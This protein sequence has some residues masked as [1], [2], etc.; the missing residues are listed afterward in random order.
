MAA[1]GST[2][3]AAEHTRRFVTALDVEHIKQILEAAVDGCGQLW[4]A[5]D[6]GGRLWTAVDA[7]GRRWT[8]VDAC[9]RLRTTCGRL[10]T[11]VD[12]GGRL[13]T[14]V[15]ACGRLWTAADNLWTAVD[16]GGRL[17]TAADN[18][19][20]AVDGCGQP[21]DGGGRLWTPVDGC[22][23][24]VDGCGICTGDVPE[25]AACAFELLSPAFDTERGSQGVE[26]H[27]WGSPYRGGNGSVGRESASGR[28]FD[29]LHAGG[30][31]A[32]RL[33]AISLSG[34]GGARLNNTGYSASERGRSTAVV[35]SRV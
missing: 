21:V 34:G 18:L 10:W 16:G 7:C 31:E 20:T 13:W 25:C 12:G 29:R 22:G 26:E 4:T 19:W 24:P 3:S 8:P 33:P 28:A 30:S 15:D 2:P 23:Q 5:V 35:S 14:A 9:G 27:P 6:G 32:R 1:A 17:W 11:A